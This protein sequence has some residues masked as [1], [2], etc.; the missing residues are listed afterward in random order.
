MRRRILML[1]LAA[2]VAALVLAGLA[3]WRVVQGGQDAVIQAAMIAGIG[4]LGLMTALWFLF[5]RHLARPLE[6]LAGALRT[7]RVPDLAQARHLAD[8]GPAARDAALARE[9]SDQALAQ[10]LQ[11]HAAE[12]LREKASLEAILADFGAGAVM[13]D[14]RGRVVSI[15]PA[16][17]G[18]CRD[19]RWTVRWTRF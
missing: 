11:D 2:L 4:L 12:T 3:L 16:R 13:A 19:W 8:L 10:A 15:T 17:R 7:G 18:C 6:S 14:A 1:F 5:D 9:R